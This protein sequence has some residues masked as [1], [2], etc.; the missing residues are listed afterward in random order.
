[1]DMGMADEVE[2][3]EY[4][5]ERSMSYHPFGVLRVMFYKERDIETYLELYGYPDLYINHGRYGLPILRHLEGKCFR[6]HV[7]ALRTGLDRQDNFGAD[8]YLVDSEE[9]LDWRSMLYVPVVNTEKIYPIN[10]EKKRDFIYLASFQASKRHDILVNAVRGT[11]LTGHLHP[12]DGAKMDLTST[13]I[14]TT[15][16]NEASVVDLLR[17]SRIAVYPGDN[18]SNPAAMW[19]CV[20]AGLPIVVNENIRGGKHLVIPGVTGEFASEDNFYDMMKYVLANRDSYRPREYFMENWDTVST[21]EKYLSFFGKM[22][23]RYSNVF[24]RRPGI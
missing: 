24:D 1:M 8:C 9:Y 10:C 11:D 14:P 12:V 15:N 20:A 21:L 7:P 6:V 17:T 4:S 22:G 2:F 23:W 13:N 18:T 5:E 19:E 16:W 3:W